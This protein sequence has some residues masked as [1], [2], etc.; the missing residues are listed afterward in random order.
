MNNIIISDFDKDILSSLKNLG[1]NVFSFGP[2]KEFNS[3]LKHHTDLFFLKIKDTLFV[4]NLVDD[5]FLKRIPQKYR[6]IT[7]NG[8]SQGYPNEASLNALYIGGRLICNTRY[9]AKEVCDF[10]NLNKIELIHVNQGY[11]NCSC[12]V[13]GKNA[14][15][16]EDEGVANNLRLTDTQVLLV[17]DVGVKLCGFDKGFIGGA[18]FFDARRSSVFFFGDIQKCTEFHRIQDFCKKQGTEIISLK[19][20]ADLLDLGSAVLL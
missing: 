7:C 20:D 16:T 9:L 2:I 15:I 14:V 13:V 17:K 12:A 18:S 4:S 3:F 10:A 8:V 1:Y 19:T 6:V 5:S 11:A